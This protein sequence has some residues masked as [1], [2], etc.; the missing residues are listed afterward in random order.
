M[1]NYM[2]FFLKI[3]FAIFGTFAV[4]YFLMENFV[5][6]EPIFSFILILFLPAILFHSFLVMLIVI[7]FVRN[8][9]CDLENKFKSE[10]CIR[11][12]NICLSLHYYAIHQLVLVLIMLIIFCVKNYSKIGNRLKL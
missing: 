6:K 3:I 2:N 4:F 8:R 11:L 10:P 5:P 1:I 9:K 12:K 7:N